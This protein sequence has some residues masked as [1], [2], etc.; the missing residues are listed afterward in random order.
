MEKTPH[1]KICMIT[2]AT[3][4]IGRETAIALAGLNY[5]I[6]LVGRNE[7]KCQI[8]R[9][10]IIQRTGNQQIDFLTADF[11]DLSQ[12]RN[13]ANEFI[14]KYPKLDILINNAG[15]YLMTRFVSV[16]GYEKTFAVN[17][18]AHFLLTNLLLE[19]LKTSPAA[20]I[21]NVSSMAH[22]KRNINFDDLSSEKNYNG[23]YAYSRS[24]LANILF[25]YEL[26]RLLKDTNIT[27]NAFHP[28]FVATNFGKNNGLVRFILRR[29]IKRGALS[30]AEGADTGI[31][32]ATLQEVKQVSGKYF[33][34]KK[35]VNSSIES[36]D[37]NLAKEL[38]NKSCEMTGL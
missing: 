38:W 15:V 13:L 7:N 2:G 31:Y 23:L 26:A 10:H 29:M 3:S 36:Y 21:I 1:S 25:T 35:A 34:N 30:P 6:I 28:G 5:S 17:H 27:V 24:K 18:L 14:K 16:D 33:V 8:T 32:L 9:K 37:E 19:K 12:I 4:G 20:R 11:A 22:D